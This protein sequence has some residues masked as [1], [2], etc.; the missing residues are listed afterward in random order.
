MF[1]KKV[2]IGLR[3]NPNIDAKT[4][5]KI[6]TGRM[7]DKFGLNSSDIIKILNKFKNSRNIKIKC[8]YKCFFNFE[9]CDFFRFLNGFLS[10]CERI[11]SLIGVPGKSNAS[12]NPF[13]KYRL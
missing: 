11:V 9:G 2:N 7:Q 5:T 4:N 6:S 12:R 1:K 8:F 10:A 3:L 13:T